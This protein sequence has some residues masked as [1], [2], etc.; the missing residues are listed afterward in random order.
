M[1]KPREERGKQENK[2]KNNKKS[3][4]KNRKREEQGHLD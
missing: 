3:K 1:G 4:I 2:S